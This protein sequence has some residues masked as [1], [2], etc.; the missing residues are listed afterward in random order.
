ME[1][2]VTDE[3]ERFLEDVRTWLN[4]TSRAGQT[5][6]ETPPAELPRHTRQLG[7]LEVWTW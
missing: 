1:P 7:A 6:R 2:T 3:Q 4:E 5:W